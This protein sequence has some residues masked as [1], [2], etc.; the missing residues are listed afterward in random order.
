MAE[1]ALSSMGGLSLLTLFGL[2]SRSLV[3]GGV[4]MGIK[5]I[6]TSKTIVKCEKLVL[7]TTCVA[8]KRINR[9]NKSC[10]KTIHRFSISEMVKELIIN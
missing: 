8:C 7:L 1:S 5:M 4:E 2:F 9:Q 3:G 10:V 6:N